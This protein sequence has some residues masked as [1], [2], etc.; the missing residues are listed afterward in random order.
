ML[1]VLELA[2][3]LGLQEVQG[4]P[5]EPVLLGPLAWLLPWAQASWEP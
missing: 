1:L 5:L 2:L 3:V 4:L